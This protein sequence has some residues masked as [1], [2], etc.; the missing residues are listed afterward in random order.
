MSTYILRRDH[1]IVTSADLTL[2]E[3]A[4]GHNLT[5][6][7]TVTGEQLTYT[8]SSGILEIVQTPTSGD[9]DRAINLDVEPRSTTAGIRQ[10][11][12]YVGMNRTASY[13]WAT[14]DGNPDCGMKM[15]V[16]NRSVSA[17]LGAVRGLDITARNRDS[18]S[19]SWINGGQVTAENSTGSGGVVNVIGFEIHS[20]NNGVASGDVKALR[21]YD[22]SQ[23]ATGTNYGIELNCTANS[24]FAREYGLYIGAGATAS[25]T[26]AVSFNDTIVNVFDFENNDGTNG[27]TLGT[28][29]SADANP[30]GHIKVDVGGATR[31]IYLYTAAVTFS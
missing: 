3:D 18:G 8:A 14:W 22:E 11:A 29:A 24:G 5:I 26:N 19:L 15:A 2:G 7:G 27:A 16:Y 21:V 1:D 28:Y 6:Y 10:G 17:T 13:P 30:S 12:I 9:S 31:Y 4:D 25:W 23:S 20:K